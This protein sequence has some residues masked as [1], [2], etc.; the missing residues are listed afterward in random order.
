MA[1]IDNNHTQQSKNTLVTLSL[2]HEYYSSTYFLLTINKHVNVNVY[3]GI[4][5]KNCLHCTVQ[6]MSETRDKFEN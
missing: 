2:M 6:Y 4:V 1:Y 5:I 3:Q